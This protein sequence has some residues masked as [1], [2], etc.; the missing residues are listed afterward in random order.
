DR[1]DRPCGRAVQQVLASQR[2]RLGPRWL[3]TSVTAGGPGKAAGAPP[4]H[5]GGPKKAPRSAANSAG[6]S[7][8]GKCLPRWN[9][10]QCASAGAGTSLRTVSS[11]PKTPK[12]LGTVGGAPPADECARS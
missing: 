5:G 6:A 12:T 3:R 4:H 10:V 1:V 7:I 9:S 11:A 2:G 8:A